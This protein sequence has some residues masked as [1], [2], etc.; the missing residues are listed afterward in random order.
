[1]APPFTGRRRFWTLQ[2]ERA[3]EVIELARRLDQLA[4][5]SVARTL[6]GRDHPSRQQGRHGRDHFHIESHGIQFVGKLVECGRYLHL[7]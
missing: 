3:V 2:G 4:R 1:M 7:P 5:L 6:C